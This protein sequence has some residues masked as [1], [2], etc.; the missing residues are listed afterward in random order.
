VTSTNS[1]DAASSGTPAVSSDSAGAG[2]ANVRDSSNEQQQQQQQ[3][4]S[5]DYMT[6]MFAAVR[7]ASATQGTTATHTEVSLQH[8]DS[9]LDAVSWHTAATVDAS[10]HPVAAATAVMQST[11][12][13]DTDASGSEMLQ[14][15]AA[16]VA[17]AA[18]TEAVTELAV[19]DTAVTETLPGPLEASSVIAIPTATTYS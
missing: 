5:V 18:V 19:T 3:Q 12:A 13:V 7:A 9:S 1:S 4:Q 6:A 17:E 16:A 2:T 15:T 8:C 11:A 14:D 10:H